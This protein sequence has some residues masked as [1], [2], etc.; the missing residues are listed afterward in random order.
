MTVFLLEVL[1]LILVHIVLNNIYFYL[2]SLL[3][4][5]FRLV[6]DFFQ[7]KNSQSHKTNGTNFRFSFSYE[8]SPD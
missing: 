8:N 4:I 6:F 1:S 7:H 3:K 2:F 5:L